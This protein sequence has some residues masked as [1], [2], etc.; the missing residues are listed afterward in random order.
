MKTKSLK[1]TLG[2]GL[3]AST[4]LIKNPKALSPMV[5]YII[6]WSKDIQSSYNRAS[7]LEEARFKLLEELSKCTKQTSLDNR[8]YKLYNLIRDTRP[9]IVV[10]TGVASGVST[11]YIL[12]ALEDNRK[13]KLYSID[14]PNQFYLTSKNVFHA[15]FNPQE[16]NLDILYQII[17][18]TDGI[19]L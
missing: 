13:G 15:E 10:E 7:D 4:F 11:A 18:D 14:L 19:L 2:V 16:N 17:L 1:W 5:K 6:G 9:S 3:K 12:Q 8:W